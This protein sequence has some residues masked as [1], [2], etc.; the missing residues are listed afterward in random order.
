MAE[1][2]DSRPHAVII[3]LP[4]AQGHMTPM[5]LL[6]QR[7]AAK[8]VVV[9]VLTI[10]RTVARMQQ[11]QQKILGATCNEV[12][13]SGPG[14]IRL[15]GVSDGL[16]ADFDL[17]IISNYFIEA[18]P[19]IGTAIEEM[20]REITLQQ[21]PVTCVIGDAFV[22]SVP[23]ITTKLNLRRCCFWPQSSTALAMFTHIQKMAEDGFDAFQGD[24]NPFGPKDP[25]SPIVCIP[26]L[27]EIHPACLPFYCSLGE[28]GAAAF[29]KWYNTSVA[30]FYECECIIGNSFEE[31]EPLQCSAFQ[32]FYAVG[33]LLPSAFVAGINSFK[34][35]TVASFWNEDECSEWLDGQA[36]SSVLYVSFG[37]LTKFS[38]AQISEVA[39]GLMASAQR[40][41][42][43]IRRDSILEPVRHVFEALP[44]NFVQSTENQGK[45]I[46]WAPQTAVLSHPAVGG[47]FS[48]CGWNSVLE[49]MI[50]GVPILAWPQLLDQ[51]TNCWAV[52]TQW[53]IG[54]ELKSDAE[55]KTER[56]EVERGVRKLM[57]GGPEAQEM[58]ER[59]AK[60]KEAGKKAFASSEK[61]LQLFVEDLRRMTSSS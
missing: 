24:M 1:P 60:L 16:P 25:V 61:T 53:K 19:R 21:P 20:L 15:I 30:R 58:R 38:I 6:A 36:E 9:T 44:E 57:E 22:E 49:S 35:R 11:V 41:L 31:L 10:Q 52:V 26:G 42:W 12:I 55:N 45:I 56:G 14:E 4:N 39:I 2:F 28:V 7:L 23:D 18:M 8:G 40:F 5:M 59:I 51:V 34:P 50:A 54:L 3:P 37:S 33:P 13:D 46:L 43:V 48:H 27:S 29:R 47:F 17:D 32:K